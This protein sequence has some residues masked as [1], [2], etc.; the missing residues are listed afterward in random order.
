MIVETVLINDEEIV[1]R[2]R[3][4]CAFTDSAAKLIC[5]L[6]KE[7]SKSQE[8]ELDEARLR[9]IQTRFV[10]YASLADLMR[11]EGHTN[12]H[13]HVAGEDSYI[14]EQSNPRTY[15]E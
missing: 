14:V 7:R 10:E 3:D 15:A 8:W 2:L 1:A 9:T 13:L 5:K 6:L 12:I 4:Y 11:E